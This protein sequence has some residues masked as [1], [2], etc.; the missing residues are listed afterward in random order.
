MLH[1]LPAVVIDSR[2][3]QQYPK[4]R[5]GASMMRH[6]ASGN[7]GRRLMVAAVYIVAMPRGGH[8]ASPS[9][10]TPKQPNSR[11]F[12]FD[13]APAQEFGNTFASLGRSS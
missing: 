11:D 13:L 5:N 7:D 3:T 6:C 1:A 12:D 10:M 4:L 2:L 9:A 8:K